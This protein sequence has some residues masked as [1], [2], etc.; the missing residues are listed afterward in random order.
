[1]LSK[2]FSLA[3]ILSTLGACKNVSHYDLSK[4][5]KEYQVAAS[6]L[7]DSI[8]KK[9][10]SKTIRV[11]ALKTIELAVP[12]LSSYGQKH[13]NCEV[14]TNFIIKKKGEMVKLTPAQLEDMYHEGNALPK[15]DEECHDIKELV[16]HPATVVSL[17]NG[18]LTKESYE[19]MF[20]EIEEVLGHF[21]TL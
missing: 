21:E 20:D 7:L 4:S 11:Q 8:E 19:Q 9:K 13:P 17:L 2:V 1:M 14:L 16:V 6:Q 5:K 18:K 10:D 3:I 12:V 15:Y